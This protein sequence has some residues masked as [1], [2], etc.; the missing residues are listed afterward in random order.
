MRNKE[1]LREI[2]RFLD[3]QLGGFTELEKMDARGTVKKQVPRSEQAAS[4]A[5]VG[6]ASGHTEPTVGC[7]ERGSGEMLGQGYV[8]TSASADRQDF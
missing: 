2:P 8:W 5:P 3:R 4:A 1:E 7:T 6:H